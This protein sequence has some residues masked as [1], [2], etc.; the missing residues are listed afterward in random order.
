MTPI[1]PPRSEAHLFAI[2][3]PSFADDSTSLNYSMY[4]SVTDA[5]QYMLSNRVDITA[6][7]T[8]SQAWRLLSVVS[9]ERDIFRVLNVKSGAL[10]SML[11]MPLHEFTFTANISQCSRKSNSSSE[12]NLSRKLPLISIMQR[13]NIVALQAQDITAARPPREIPHNLPTP[14][15]IPRP[16]PRRKERA[17][18]TPQAQS[19]R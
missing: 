5:T 7:E 3:D 14:R 16:R 12:S 4:L 10:N 11:Q 13:L 15:A 17:M 8:G 2:Q 18:G 6:E 9:V 1:H 19:Q